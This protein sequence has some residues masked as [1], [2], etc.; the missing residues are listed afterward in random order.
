VTVR[1]QSWKD[2]L[3]EYIR[4]Q[5]GRVT[6]TRLQIAEVFFSMD[7][8]PGIEDIAEEVRRR[9]PGTGGASIYRTMRLLC[10][11]GLAEE[12]QFG[13]GFS[14]FE[15]KGAP[16]GTGHHDHLIC[17][18]CG[19]IVEFGDPEIERLQDRAA[20]LHGFEIRSHRL[21]IFGICGKCRA[22]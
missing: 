19:E 18:D 4:G 10:D 7:G 3:T 12:C 6:P 11:A 2:C 15:A 9:H 20:E 17:L 14:R 8:H 16:G 1:R 5:G 22:R 13:D 21:E